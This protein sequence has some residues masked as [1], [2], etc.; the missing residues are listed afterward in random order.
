MLVPI[1]VW[2]YNCSTH[3][4]CICSA[5]EPIMWSAPWDCEGSDDRHIS[6]RS[7]WSCSLFADS[8]N[9]RPSVTMTSI[10]LQL[11]ANQPPPV[12]FMELSKGLQFSSKWFTA[13]WHARKFLSVYLLTSVVCLRRGGILEGCWSTRGL[14]A[15]VTNPE[16]GFYL[17]GRKL[18]YLQAERSKFN[19]GKESWGENYFF[20]FCLQVRQMWTEEATSDTAIYSWSWPARMFYWTEFC[21]LRCL[22]AL[23][24]C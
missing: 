22:R 18:N 20:F 12:C 21:N 9:K 23:F 17:A 24:W 8:Y 6:L 11:K 10:W 15:M 5:H 4:S 2:R 13:A 19:M 14:V 1:L 3:G 7:S 16:A